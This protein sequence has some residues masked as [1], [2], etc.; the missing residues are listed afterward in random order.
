[1]T[2]DA[3]LY[4]GV[5]AVLYALFDENERLDHGAMAAQV[6]YCIAAGCHGITVL[7]LAT[8]VLKLSFDERMALLRGVGRALD[9]RLPL[10][11]TIAGNSV[12]EQAA[13]AQ[14]AADAGADW[15]ILQPPMVG[16]YGADI[17]LDI[18]ARVAAA[19]P[20]PVAV[21]NAPQYLGRG[22][23]GEDLA[24]LRS[25]VGNLRAV[26]AEDAALGIRRIIEI[27]GAELQVLGG[28]G[29]LEMTDCLRA[30]CNGFVLAPDIAPVAARIFDLWDSGRED[31]AERLYADALPA[32]TFV[33]QSLEHLITYGKRIFAE[34]AGLPV[35]DRA[36]CLPPTPF[37][38]DMAG[39]W[40][41]SLRE[42][43]HR[44]A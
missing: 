18:F 21:Q 25:R 3:K 38:L 43:S 6:D 37:G 44:A 33:M 29:G 41:A 13:L 2:G 34:N 35:H 9:G 11:V 20:L 10:S 42:L 8:E 26:K 5:H 24:R 30:G 16:S 17:Y 23:S 15:L 7:G 12:A 27:A 1:M 22:L 28:R 40:A 36:P 31:A 14:A 4:R 19:T 39:R 32:A